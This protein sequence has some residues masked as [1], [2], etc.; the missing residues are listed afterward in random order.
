MKI[1][2]LKESDVW[3][4]RERTMAIEIK[5]PVEGCVIVKKIDKEKNMKI[6][7]MEKKIDALEKKLKEK[8]KKKK[9]NLTGTEKARRRN[10]KLSTIIDV[11]PMLSPIQ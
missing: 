11:E 10:A 6:N 4:R 9:K 8:K 3:I 5:I 1:E 7:E 2:N